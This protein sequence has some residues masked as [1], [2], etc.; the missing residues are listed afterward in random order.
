MCQQWVWG[1]ASVAPSQGAVLG[2]I[3]SVWPQVGQAAIT[4]PT[5]FQVEFGATEAE[6]PQWQS[7]VRSADWDEK[8][9][10]TTS[11][12]GAN[13]PQD[14]FGSQV[15]SDQAAHAPTRKD[16]CRLSDI[17]VQE[18][19]DCLQAKSAQLLDWIEEFEPYLV[20]GTL[21]YWVANRIPQCL[22]SDEEDSIGILA[23]IE[24]LKMHV[25]HKPKEGTCTILQ[26]NVTHYRSEVRQWLVSNQCQITCL[27]ET[28]VEKHQQEAMKSGL[29]AG[30]MEAW[31]AGGNTGGLVSTARSHLQTRHLITHGDQGKGFAFIGIRFHGWELAVGNVY[32]E[33]GKGPGGGVNPQLFRNYGYLGS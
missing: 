21:G 25:G 20:P 7:E 33:S 12:A 30:S 19:A 2:P 32:L 8:A 24:D 28:H 18:P 1:H 6:E 5:Y 31:T 22:E 29:A 23:C 3:A 11:I 27:Q 16:W 17:I 13:Q 10:D 15:K 26:A 9:G 14:T 4:G